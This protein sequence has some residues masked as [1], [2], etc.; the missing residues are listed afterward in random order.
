MI[1]WEDNR[2]YDLLDRICKKFRE[3]AKEEENQEVSIKKRKK[4]GRK[5]K[6]LEQSDIKSFT[7]TVTGDVG[8]SEITKYDYIIIKFILTIRTVYFYHRRSST[9]SSSNC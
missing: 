9:G 1:I 3:K 6:I 8:K 7:T 4:R 2:I 5:R